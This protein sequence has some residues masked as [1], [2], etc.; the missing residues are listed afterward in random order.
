MR[1]ENA[2]DD[3]K[4][5]RHRGEDTCRHGIDEDDHNGHLIL[6]T[7]HFHFGTIIPILE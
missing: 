4:D 3:T 5:A 7:G 1:P 6:P 2:R